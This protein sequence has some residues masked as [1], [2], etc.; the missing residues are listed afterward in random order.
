[1]IR[2]FA[3]YL[4]AVLALVA[5]VGAFVGAR[6]T[7]M[8]PDAASRRTVT[9][10]PHAAPPAPAPAQPRRAATGSDSPGRFLEAFSSSHPQ[11]VILRFPDGAS[12]SDFLGNALPVGIAV[13]HPL[14]PLHAIRLQFDEWDHVTELLA[15]LGFSGF[16]QVE[17]SP[18]F[19]IR[20]DGIGGDALGFSDS[21]IDWLGVPGDHSKWG[22]GVRVAVLDTGVVPHPELPQG[23]R[24]IAIE[25]FPSDLGETNPH[26][27]AVAS[28]IA[29]Q[30]PRVEGLAPAAEILSIRVMDDSG[31]ADSFNVAAGV[32]AAIE[33][34]VH[35]I[36]LS[37]GSLEENS[38]EADAIR[39][40]QEAGIVVVAAAGNDGYDR[41]RYPAAYPGVISVGAIDAGG[42]RMKFSNTGETLSLT[43]PGVAVLAAAPGGTYVQTSGTSASA[44]LVTAAIAATMSDGTGRFLGAREAAAI[45]LEHCDDI[46]PAGQDP[47][48]GAGILNLNRI[49]LRNTPGIVDACLTDQRL[50]RDDNGELSLVVTVQNRGTVALSNSLVHLGGSPALRSISIP[51]LG[52]NESRAVVFRGLP[53]S[54]D[55][56]SA[57]HLDLWLELAGGLT[58]SRPG[59]FHLRLEGTV[60]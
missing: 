57:F 48:Y 54:L 30:G 60:P 47:E 11:Q 23:F 1:M 58:P 50:V 53:A 32:L 2:R 13:L 27:T 14:D 36:N 40:A 44:P 24:S 4:P 56:G 55:R 59:S 21:A 26:G 46:G 45:V 9:V 35:L 51:L 41:L 49:M 7:G 31:S 38:L 28:I 6:G 19:A 8:Q 10:R 29:G 16:E 39:L 22:A 12:Y 3:R 42:E 17:A 5:G 18:G 33:A 52:P 34:R 25:P 15:S 43:A 37:I 20:G